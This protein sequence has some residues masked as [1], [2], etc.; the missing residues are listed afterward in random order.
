M[1]FNAVF[2]A[3]AVRFSMCVFSALA[4]RLH[5]L[6]LYFQSIWNIFFHLFKCIFFTKLPLHSFAHVHIHLRAFLMRSSVEKGIT[7]YFLNAH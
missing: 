5:A 4:V 1:F 6:S 7:L 3:F 2:N